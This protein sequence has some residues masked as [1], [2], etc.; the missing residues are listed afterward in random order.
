VACFS[1]CISAEFGDVEETHE[2]F[3]INFSLTKAKQ[4]LPSKKK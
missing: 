3:T 2:K 4:S 1:I